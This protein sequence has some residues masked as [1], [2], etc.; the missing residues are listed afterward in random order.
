MKKIK[1]NK[2]INLFLILINILVSLIIIKE[3][4]L[5]GFCYTIINLIMPLFF[6]FTIAW[7]LKPIMLKINKKFSVPVSASLTYIIFI[8]LI[9]IIIYF[10]IPVIVGE[11]K[12]LIPYIIKIY[13]KMPPRIIDSVN[14]SEIGKKAVFLI[15]NYTVNIKNLAL[16]I[17]YSIFIS[18]YFLIGHKNVTKFI[19]KYIP[20][21]LCNDISLNLKA[22][23]KGK[24]KPC[25]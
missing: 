20:S 15:N 23:V 10:F 21:S 9:S 14:I 13:N 8:F 2:L 4:K 6:G 16:N 1:K 17:F 25:Y 5:I 3:C 19:S 24:H 18:F 11:V 12:N 7:L 22:F